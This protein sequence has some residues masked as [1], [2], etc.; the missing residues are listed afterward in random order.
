MLTGSSTSQIIIMHCIQTSHKLKTKGI[1]T[2]TKDSLI[3]CL[4]DGSGECD[5]FHTNWFTSLSSSG[6]PFSSGW[7]HRHPSGGTNRLAKKTVSCFLFILL[8]QWCWN[9]TRSNLKTPPWLHSCLEEISPIRIEKSHRSMKVITQNFVL[10]GL[11][12]A[13]RAVS[14]RF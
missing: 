7:K 3:K 2:H 13:S 14:Y 5:Q 11:L 9:T 4:N 6:T 8:L 10:I 12:Q 1:I